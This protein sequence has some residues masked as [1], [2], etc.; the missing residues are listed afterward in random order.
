MVF[1]TNFPSRHKNHVL[2]TMSYK[3]FNNAIPDY[4]VVRDMTERDY[5]FDAMLELT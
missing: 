3:I 5:G 2:E 4:W 1:D